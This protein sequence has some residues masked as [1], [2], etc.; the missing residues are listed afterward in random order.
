M[1]IKILCL[2]I[3]V[4][5]FSTSATEKTQINIDVDKARK[6]EPPSKKIANFNEVVQDRDF[7]IEYKAKLDALAKEQGVT[8]N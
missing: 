6:K 8:L 4:L 7:W 2:L 5:I 1:K 3:F